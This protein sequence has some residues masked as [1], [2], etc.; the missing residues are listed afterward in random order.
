VNAR[1]GSWLG[2]VLSSTL[3][4]ACGRR[5]QPEAGERLEL[6]AALGQS[7]E[8]AVA[9]LE[10]AQAEPPASALR[11][12]TPSCELEYQLR[13]TIDIEMIDTDGGLK[14]A[15][16]P[17]QGLR[18]TGG[19]TA[20]TEGARMLLRHRD[21]TLAQLQDGQQR[22]ANAQPPGT[23]AEIRLETDGRAWTEVEGPTALWSAFGSWMG[24]VLFHPALPET[25]TVGAR[26]T[27]PLLVHARGSG[28]RVEVERGSMKVPDGFEF[29]EPESDTVLT[30]VELQR[31]IDIAGTRAAVLRSQFQID[32]DSPFSG[33]GMIG[34]LDT[35]K[36]SE[37]QY[38]LLDSGVL[39]HVELQ[40]KTDVQM[41]VGLG[42][43]IHQ[44]HTL[45]GEARL[46]GSCTGPVLPRFPDDRTPSERAFELVV[47]LRD[48]AIAGELEPLTGM[49]EGELLAA[50][51]EAARCL[52]STMAR[53]GWRALGTPELPMADVVR[54]DGDRVSMT[55]HV[56]LT[57]EP[58][59]DDEDGGDVELTVAVEGTQAKL[60]AVELRRYGD[61]EPLLRLDAGQALLAAAGCDGPSPKP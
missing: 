54:T 44:V 7:F 52:V 14:G 25:S 20:Q 49:L 15:T 17:K 38:V 41:S 11:W 33:F 42:K 8:A 57:G 22:P 43:S 32:S 40:E 16:L 9:G 55:L 37:G 60:A 18:I 35:D 36:T 4:L 50:H 3:V 56:R 12:Q 13:V 59:S 21:L 10:V 28:A 1:L 58:G 39:L 26:T 23:L 61:D 46:V 5:N 2:F 27:W 30:Q 45:V 19:W 51:P 34:S 29:T 53:F 24:L 48:H 31:W 47:A 6:D